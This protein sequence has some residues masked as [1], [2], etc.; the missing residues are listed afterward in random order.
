MTEIFLQMSIE[1]IEWIL[2]YV[3]L[4]FRLLRFLIIIIIKCV[5]HHTLE[6]WLFFWTNIRLPLSKIKQLAIVLHQRNMTRDLKIVVVMSSAWWRS[7]LGR[8]DIKTS[9]E[10]IVTKLSLLK[11]LA[12][13]E[14]LLLFFFETKRETSTIF[15]L[16]VNPPPALRFF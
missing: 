2:K 15:L 8:L 11:A 7:S 4:S 16:F 13:A 6:A 5:L 10:S 3:M 1:P 14:T 9:W 12:D